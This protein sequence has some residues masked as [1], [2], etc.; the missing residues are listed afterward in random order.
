MHVRESGDAWR[1]LQNV[2]RAFGKRI[3]SG[4]RSKRLV[5]DAYAWSQTV[6]AVYSREKTHPYCAQRTYMHASEV[7]SSEV[8]R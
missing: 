7:A 6:N 1:N 5:K 3:G 4:K 8:V 2:G